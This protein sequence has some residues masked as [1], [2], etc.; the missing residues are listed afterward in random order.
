[1]SKSS[2]R[3]LYALFALVIGFPALAD[4]AVPIGEI[5]AHPESYH[6]RIIPIQGTVRRVEVLKPHNPV[7]PGDPCYGAYAIV[8]E[9][10]T[11]SLEAGVFGHTWKCNQPIEG[12]APDVSVGD[13]VLLQVQIRAPG[14]YIEEWRS[15]IPIDRST[16]QAIAVKITHL[17][18]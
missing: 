8:V 2:S 4:E 1:M 5:L 14:H 17:G 16:T 10:K 18:K 9:D 13:K 15:P 6:L 7:Q 12:D 3:W 11:G